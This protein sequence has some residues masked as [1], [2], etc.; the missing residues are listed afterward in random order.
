MAGLDPAIHALPPRTSRPLFAGASHLPGDNARL[1]DLL[2]LTLITATLTTATC[3]AAGAF[4]WPVL[5]FFAAMNAICLA[6]GRACLRLPITAFHTTAAYIL[7]A[8]LLSLFIFLL[9]LIFTLSAGPAAL[10][11]SAIGL[12]I[13]WR[14]KPKP[15]PATP[16]EIW[17]TLL[18]CLA[19]FIW[20]W[21]AIIAVPH[22]LQNH[23]F[24]AWTDYFIHAG[25]LSQ[26]ADFQALHGTSIF[27]AGAP[28][29]PYHYAS[30]MLPAALAGLTNVLSLTAITAFWTPFGVLLM[31]F[32]ASVLGG[33]L[34][35]ERAGIFALIAVFLIPSA[36]HYGL[37]NPFFDFHWLIEISTS[38]GYAFACAAL[39]LA[40]IIFWLRN[41]NPSHLA[42]MAALTF[43]TALFRVHIFAPLVLTNAV[44]FFAAW[45]PARRWAWPAGLAACLAAAIAAASAA[46]LLP[47]AP[48]LFT[49]PHHPAAA[50]L[51]MLGMTP[52][53][54]AKLFQHLAAAYPGFALAT[55]LTL[56]AAA[57]FGLLLP[58][59]LITLF[60]RRVTFEAFIPLAALTAY[61]TI[62]IIVPNNPLEPLEFAH[63]PFVFVYGLLAIWTAAF[64]A[65]KLP[66]RHHT[67]LALAASFLLLATPLALQST[68]QKSNLD[69][70]ALFYGPKIPP[71]LIATAAYLRAHAARHAVIAA[72]ASPL[73]EP[74][75]ALSERPE[76]FP[77]TLFLYLQSGLSPAGQA[78]RAAAQNTSQS[79]GWRVT[80]PPTKPPPNAA[81][82]ASG[83][84]VQQIFPK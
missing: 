75:I 51:T 24:A 4:L 15:A 71:G 81:F 63:R 33:V 38:A 68:A 35:G 83:F 49:G 16:A 10:I 34:A 20:Y 12:A 48:H 45:R 74:L 79:I 26:F 56:L 80:F 22:L 61:Y 39:S 50:L 78:A 62:V 82:T 66:A 30:Y 29:P 47:R 23:V 40:A 55:G 2:F 21:Q 60:R 8:L 19:T 28:L 72:P 58:L 1:C 44:L 73:D 57:A 9:C 70:A 43:L 27:A 5:V 17:A 13:A 54:S 3:I 59:Y 76:F 64:I 36:A 14:A 46:E 53:P 65:T 69:A 42:W 18:A 6:T 41:K 32:A 7:G 52:S 31:A 77:G 11:G 67:T 84:S 25:E 37:K